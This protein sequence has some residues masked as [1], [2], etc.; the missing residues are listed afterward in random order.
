VEELEGL[1]L[2]YRYDVFQFFAQGKNACHEQV[3]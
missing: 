3:R 2:I 1:E